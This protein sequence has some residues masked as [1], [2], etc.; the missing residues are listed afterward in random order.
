MK[1]K[2]SFRVEYYL[3]ADPVWE[4]RAQWL[5]NPSTNASTLRQALSVGR[6]LRRHHKKVR[7]IRIEH[8]EVVC[9]KQVSI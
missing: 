7:I 1:K 9:A 5:S 4:R 2:T 3:P 8:V 6:Y